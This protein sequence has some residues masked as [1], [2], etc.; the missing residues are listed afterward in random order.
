[1]SRMFG[2]L[3]ALVAVV[4]LQPVGVV[5][6]QESAQEPTEREPLMPFL[7]N[8]ED[9]LTLDFLFSL[10]AERDYDRFV[11]LPGFDKERPPNS[12]Y[13]TLSAILD[14][15]SRY[16]SLFVDWGMIN[17][18]RYDATEPYMRGRY[19]FINDAHVQVEGESFSVKAGRTTQK[20]VVDTPYSLFVNSRPIPA[21]QLETNYNGTYFFY[22]NRWVSLNRNS[23]LIYFGTDSDDFPLRGRP[24]SV[25]GT[26]DTFDEVYADGIPWADRG[27]NFKVYGLNLGRWRFGIQESAVYINQSFNPEFFFSPMPLYFTQLVVD[28]GGDGAFPWGEYANSKHIF[29]FF[30]DRTTEDTY[31]AGQFLFD[32]INGGFIPG[33]ETDFQDRLAWSIGGHRDFDFGR[34]G[35]YYAGATK[36]TFSATSVLERWQ[37]RDRNVTQFTG[38][39]EVPLYYSRRP[40]PLTYYPAVEFPDDDGKKRLPIDY[41]DNY[42]GYMHGENNMALMLTYMNVFRPDTGGIG[43]H[44]SLEYVVNGAKSPANP[45][46]EEDSYKDISDSFVLLNDGTLEHQLRL[47]AGVQKDI[48]IFDTPFSVFAEG[49]LA[50]LFNRMRISPPHKNGEVDIETTELNNDGD[51][52]D[53]PD[54]TIDRNQVE[55]WI[56]RPQSGEHDVIGQLTL[57]VV[58]RFNL[59]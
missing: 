40:Y 8:T 59:R 35:L 15:R 2:V 11:K 28:S 16:F 44:S 45:W 27:S 1:M 17:D 30:A 31:I 41:R 25:P 22:S 39:D 43:F 57:G 37:E 13:D 12:I 54:R 14:Y 47:R 49:E 9:T 53:G 46:H 6:A 18:G 24:E 5:V 56:Y 29:G 32:D 51:I 23:E 19:L 58:Y 20:D 10:T 26:G 52:V 7:G 55:P 21:L 48:R 4:L 42:I 34:V 38:S 33:I 50:V 3:G 36:Y